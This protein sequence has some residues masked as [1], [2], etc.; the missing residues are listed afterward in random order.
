MSFSLKYGQNFGNVRNTMPVYYFN[1]VCCKV[2]IFSDQTL[3]A[4]TTIIREQ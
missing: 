2:G 1:T 3:V 4:M